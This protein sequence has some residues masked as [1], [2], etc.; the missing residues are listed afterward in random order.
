[1][2]P[3][4]VLFGVET[5][6]ACGCVVSPDGGDGELVRCTV[7]RP[8]PLHSSAGHIVPV[9]RPILIERQARRP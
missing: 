4:I 6:L 9:S 8:C 3:A 1:M 5:R 7:V 2:R